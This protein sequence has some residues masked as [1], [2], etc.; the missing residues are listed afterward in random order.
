MNGRHAMANDSE[1]EARWTN[2]GLYY[3]YSKAANPIAEGLTTE[4]P[5]AD[6]SHHLHEN[7]PTRVI[8]FDLSQ[9]LK[10]PGP[11]TSPALCSNFIRIR[12]GE[13]IRTNPNATSELYYVIRGKGRTMVHNE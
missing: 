7:G 4:V 9:E 12:E 6:F 10:C 8:P 11:A 3:E 1:L 13:H 2:D 5:M